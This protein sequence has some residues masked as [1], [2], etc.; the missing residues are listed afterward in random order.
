MVSKE[1]LEI[2]FAQLYIHWYKPK[3]AEELLSDVQESIFDKFQK[4]SP[5][6]A[7]LLESLASCLSH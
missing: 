5:L 1:W 3:K 6:Y 2:H 7:T 4:T